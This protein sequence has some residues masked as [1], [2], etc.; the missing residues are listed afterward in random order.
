MA[1]YAAET[2][3]YKNAAIIYDVSND[4][5]S[6]MADALLK[7]LKAKG[8]KIIAIAVFTAGDIN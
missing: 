8:G 2:L 1:N 7:S 3:G 5:S 6:G 4:Y